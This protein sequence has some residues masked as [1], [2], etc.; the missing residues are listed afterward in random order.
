M[1]QLLKHIEFVNKEIFFSRND[2]NDIRLG[3]IVKSN[4]S[5]Y[6]NANEIVIGCPQDEGV[7][8]NKGRSGASFAPTE[9]R[10]ALYR[11]PVTDSHNHLKPFDLGNIKIENT[12]EEIH[13]V[14]FNVVRKIIQD[15]KKAIILGGGNDISYP[16]CAALCSVEN[17]VLTFNIDRH[18]DIR[19]DEQINSGTPYRRLL[20]EG[21]ITPE[22]FHEVGINSF[23]N[24][25][26]YIKCAE[27][28]GVHIHYLGELRE[29]GVGTSIQSITQSTNVD[30]IFWG[31]DMDVVR[32]VEAPGVSDPNPMGLTARQVCEIADVV[33]KDSRTKIIEITEVNP[34]Y[35]TN[36][37]T[38]KLAAN[39]IIRALAK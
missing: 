38:S 4:Y 33:S 9:I 17:R 2:P 30:A 7:R 24:S 36:G 34:H 19:S 5:D 13:D 1:N 21:I 18:L 39:I 12:L 22:L 20:D 10:K 16:D 37:I 25:P 14:L 8:R 29:K 6:A 11:Y 32:S 23:S 15:G 26:R 27:E 35:D 3:D 31:F 28:L